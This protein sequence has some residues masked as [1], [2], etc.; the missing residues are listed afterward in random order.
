VIGGGEMMRVD[1]QNKETE[2]REEHEEL[3]RAGRL[4]MEET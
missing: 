2:D 4:P 3:E 1:Q